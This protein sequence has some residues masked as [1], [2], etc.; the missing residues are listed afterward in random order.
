MFRKVLCVTLILLS[1]TALCAYASTST[2]N[3]V[4]DDIEIENVAYDGKMNISATTSV[5]ARY[6]EDSKS[7]R[8]YFATYKGNRLTGVTS[9]SFSV[10]GGQTN[11]NVNV[12]GELEYGESFKVFLIESGTL[13]P[14]THFATKEF[15][16]R[17]TMDAVDV[18]DDSLDIHVGDDDVLNL[19]GDIKIFSYW[20]GGRALNE[21]ISTVQIADDARIKWN[22]SSPYRLTS[23]NMDRDSIVG[24]RGTVTLYDDD[25]DFEYETIEVISYNAAYIKSI[26]QSTKT[27]TFGDKKDFDAGSVSLNGVNNL[28]IT[29]N[30]QEATFAD[31]QA[32]DVLHIAV[33]NWQNPS[34]CK[35]NAS[36]NVVTGTVTAHNAVEQCIKID[37]EVYQV[38][39]DVTE[40]PTAGSEGTFYLDPAGKLHFYNLTY[41]GSVVEGMVYGLS[42]SQHYII[43][44]D[45]QYTVDT[46]YTSMPMFGEYYKFYFNSAGNIIFCDMISSLELWGNYGYIAD[47]AMDGFGGVRLSLITTDNKLETFVVEQNVSI[48]REDYV[49][50]VNISDTLTPNNIGFIFL[51]RPASSEELVLSDIFD[52]ELTQPLTLGSMLAAMANDIALKSDFVL[53]GNTTYDRVI[54]YYET[55]GVINK[56]EFAKATASADVFGAYTNGADKRWSSEAQTLAGNKLSDTAHVFVIDPNGDIEKSGCGSIDLL[57]D[58]Q[59]YDYCLY[60][61]MNTGMKVAV[62]NGNYSCEVP[63]VTYT[64]SHGYLYDAIDNGLGNAGVRFFDEKDIPVSGIMHS[65]ISIN[66]VKKSYADE[67]YTIG[68]INTIFGSSLANTSEPAYISDIFEGGS[69]AETVTAASLIANLAN[70]TP[71]VSAVSPTGSAFA[72]RMTEYKIS[73]EYVITEIALPKKNASTG[74]FGYVESVNEAVYN[75]KFA[76]AST[77]IDENCKI[78]EISPSGISYCECD[79]KGALVNGAKYIAHIYK[80]ASGSAYIVIESVDTTPA[81]TSSDICIFVEA[82]ITK[83][84]NDYCYAVTYI[85]NGVLSET[86]LYFHETKANVTQM[87]KGDV[88]I[89][90]KNTKNIVVDSAIIFSPGSTEIQF[91]TDFDNYIDLTDLEDVYKIAGTSGVAKNEVYF[92]YVYKASAADGGTQVILAD[93]SGSISNMQQ[94]LIPKT[95]GITK[96]NSALSEAYKVSVGEVS[97]IVS[98]Y[99]TKTADGSMDL[100]S[101]DLDDMRYGFV[102]VTDGEVT[103]FICVQYAR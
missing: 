54:R 75:G 53:A 78:F 8:M 65:R 16:T 102:K 36:R 40:V 35:I 101:A 81:L 69:A 13:K 48:A 9:K 4:V 61:Y 29:L 95:I 103:D 7:V 63:E 20:E 12:D 6:T 58:G 14:L 43:V 5:S 60:G 64:T 80:T 85:Q 59:K 49:T 3:F 21:Q 25:R 87:C 50:D 93:E 67:G 1:L 17:I 83:L 51:N 37:T 72:D 100:E 77:V 92:G 52:T 71:L 34:F 57:V 24:K 74:E 11:N 86:P 73:S 41:T 42:S 55:D 68:D 44:D 84:N 90:A 38:S 30:G 76:G 31:L 97:D 46:N 89:Y 47:V 23:T 27:I 26:N 15:P 32:N 62:V 98:C 96:Y 70:G 22:N 66:G 45:K 2:E 88:F 82:S 18:Y 99:V 94:F 19:K 33:D 39:Y 79:D 91:G 56:L 28:S 10:A